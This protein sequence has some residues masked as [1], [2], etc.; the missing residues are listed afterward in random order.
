MSLF[1]ILSE[2]ID[3]NTITNRAQFGQEVVFLA[4]AYCTVL[5]ADS[6]TR[7]S[8]MSMMLSVSR[9]LLSVYMSMRGGLV[10]L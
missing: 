8:S 4:A 1:F 7:E 10:S 3:F 2:S 9:R 5:Y 6:R